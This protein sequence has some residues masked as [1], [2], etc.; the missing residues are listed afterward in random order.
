MKCKLVIF[1]ELLERAKLPTLMNRR[2]QDICIMYCYGTFLGKRGRFQIFL[3]RRLNSA[4][5][6][7]RKIVVSIGVTYLLLEQSL[8]I[9]KK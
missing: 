9:Y 1:T 8:G 3:K 5:F 4:I 7:N 2:L 6:C